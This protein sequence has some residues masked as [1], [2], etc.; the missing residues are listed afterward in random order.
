ML[1]GNN[2]QVR[3]LLVCEYILKDDKLFIFEYRS[4]DI[5]VNMAK[6]VLNNPKNIILK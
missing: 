6:V 2:K 4:K 1:A 3:E 5:Y